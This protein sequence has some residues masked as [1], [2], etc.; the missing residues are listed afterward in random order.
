MY[1][2]E[3]VYQLNKQGKYPESVP[4]HNASCTGY[5]IENRMSFVYPKDSSRIWL[6]VDFNQQR[7]KI[8]FKLAHS[9]PKELVYWY[10][11]DI[12]LGTTSVEHEKV[13]DV[14]EGWH[15]MTVNGQNGARCSV[16]FQVARI[17]N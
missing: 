8:V 1:P 16:S 10:I 17:N 13:L 11:D 5:H 14:D 6:P 9:Q 7:Q 2:P 4:Q 12:Y 15:T 3:V